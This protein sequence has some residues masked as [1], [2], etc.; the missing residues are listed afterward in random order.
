MLMA[1]F[2]PQI[3]GVR[4]N[5]STNWAT[6]TA[7]FCELDKAAKKS[8]LTLF[9]IQFFKFGGAAEHLDADRF[10]DQIQQRAVSDV[11]PDL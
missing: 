10:G 6:T 4:S 9:K 3:S 11:C 5:R 8:T 7:Q 1:G 2:K